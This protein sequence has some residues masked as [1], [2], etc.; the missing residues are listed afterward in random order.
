VNSIPAPLFAIANV[1]GQEQINLQMPWEVAGQGIVTIVVNNNGQ[2]SAPIQVAMTQTHPG[3]FTVGGMNGAILHANGQ[4]VTALNPAAKGETV[5]IYA[6]GLGPVANNPGTGR[7]ASGNSRT[8]ITPT[9]AIGAFF[10]GRLCS[11][12]VSRPGSSACIR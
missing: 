11:S 9:V 5:S 12:R 7:P 8:T 4:L 10:L 3:L 6:T 1:N 2:V